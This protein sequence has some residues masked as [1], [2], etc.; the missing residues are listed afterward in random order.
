M[1]EEQQQNC[2]HLKTADLNI[3]AYDI[4]YHLDIPVIRT[5]FLPSKKY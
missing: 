2:Y 4:L 5:E 1:V 3:L